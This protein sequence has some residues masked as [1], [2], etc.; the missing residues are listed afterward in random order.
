MPAATWSTA[1]FPQDLARKS[2]SAMITRLMPNGQ[3]PLFGITSMLKEETAYQPE[4]GYFS[5]TM[6]FPMVNLDA[7]VADGSATTFTVAS[8]ANIVPGMILQA[9]STKENILVATVASATSITVVRG[10]GTVAAAAIANDVNL[11]MVG[12]AYEEASVRPA[13][14]III[15]VRVINYTQIFRNTWVTSGTSAATSVIAGSAP[16]AENRQDCA[17]FHAVDIEKAL[18]FGQSFAGT[19]NG[20]PFRCM[21]GL[22]NRVTVAASANVTTLAATTNYTQLKN[23]LD[24]CFNVTTDPKVANE[25][26]LF[27][28]GGR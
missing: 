8:T 1:S 24:V 6:I 12:N 19:R 3:A 28:G 10:V 2:F 25:R 27:V 16:D 7:A 11:W 13:S 14:L 15:P 23:A 4:H 9:D 22:V 20:F 21:D 26:V 17:S 18:L 5:K